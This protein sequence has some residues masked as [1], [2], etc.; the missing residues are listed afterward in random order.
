MATLKRSRD[1]SLW[2]KHIDDPEGS[3]LS[4]LKGLKAGQSVVLRVGQRTGVWT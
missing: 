1:H 4:Q 2:F 3:L